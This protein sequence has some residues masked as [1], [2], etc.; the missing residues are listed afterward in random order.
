MKLI[1]ASS[2]PRR[3]DLLKQAHLDFKTLLADIDETWRP[4]E[5]ATDYIVRMASNKAKKASKM[6]LDDESFLVLSADTIGVLDGQVLTKPKDKTDAFLMW[7]ALSDKTHEVWTA[8]Q[9]SVVKAGVILKKQQVL[10]KTSVSFVKLSPADMSYYWQTGEPHDKA[11][12]YAIQGYG[13]TWVRSIQGSYSNVVGLPL[14]ETITLIKR[15]Q[16]DTDVN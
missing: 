4:E 12:G 11:G 8:V 6:L 15:L 7:R 5:S 1:L 2:S 13:A 14:A 16:N 10:C 3:A 9:A